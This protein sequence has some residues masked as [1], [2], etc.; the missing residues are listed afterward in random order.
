MNQSYY[1]FPMQQ[2]RFQTLSTDKEQ[3]HIQVDSDIPLPVREKQ[4]IRAYE[5][6]RDC[7]LVSTTTSAREKEVEGRIIYVEKT[8]SA[9]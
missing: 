7:F 4:I 9:I 3:M 8:D 2:Q 5:D 6:D 1:F